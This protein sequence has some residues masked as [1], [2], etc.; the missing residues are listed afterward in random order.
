VNLSTC[1]RAGNGDFCP[2]YCLEFRIH[3]AASGV[4]EI[5]VQ[6]TF[7]SGDESGMVGFGKLAFM[8]FP[9]NGLLNH[10][11]EIL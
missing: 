6:K 3:L 9:D 2:T 11:R 7:H 1:S 5:E 8:I 4:F 10:L